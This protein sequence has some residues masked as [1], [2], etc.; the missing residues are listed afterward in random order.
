MEILDA[1]RGKLYYYKIYIL[2][3]KKLDMIYKIHIECIR[4]ETERG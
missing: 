3:V 2:F 1:Q 4:K